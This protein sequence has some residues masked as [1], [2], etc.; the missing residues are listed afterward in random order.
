MLCSS[1]RASWKWWNCYGNR[2]EMTFAKECPVYKQSI[3]R[4]WSEFAYVDEEDNTN[5]IDFCR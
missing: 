2:D 3:D 5:E 4:T 1:W